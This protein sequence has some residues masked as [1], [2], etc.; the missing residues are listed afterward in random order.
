VRLDV[1]LDSDS[2]VKT[3]TSDEPVAQQDDVALGSREVRLV[4]RR[5]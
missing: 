4:L 2:D 5:R 3:R 1:R